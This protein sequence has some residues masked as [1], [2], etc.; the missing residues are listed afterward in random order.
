MLILDSVQ[1]VY[2][3]NQENLQYTE[4]EP[5]EVLNNVVTRMRN[6]NLYPKGLTRRFLQSVY[7]S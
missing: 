5:E 7:S 2:P 1:C 3:F 4:V 6:A